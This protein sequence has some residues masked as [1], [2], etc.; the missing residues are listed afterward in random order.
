MRVLPSLIATV[1]LLL[2]LSSCGAAAAL[3]P[4]EG[5]AGGASGGSGSSASSGHKFTKVAEYPLGRPIAT[6]RSEIG[7][8]P[9]TTA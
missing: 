3:R 5:A 1:V 2:A 7:S 9:Q 6:A 4:Q 8:R